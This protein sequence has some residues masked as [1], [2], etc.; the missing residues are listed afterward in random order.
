M[1]LK[2][3]VCTI[4]IMLPAYVNLEVTQHDLLQKSLITDKLIDHTCTSKSIIIVDKSSII[5]TY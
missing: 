1:D 2:L 5:S 3:K 4:K